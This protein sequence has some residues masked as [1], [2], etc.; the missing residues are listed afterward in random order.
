MNSTV[1][2]PA[3]LNRQYDVFLD[4]CPARH[5]HDRISSKWVSLV[6][7]ALSGGEKRFRDLTR[8]ISG[9][10]QKMLTQT[11]RNLERDG[12]ISR[13]VIATRP[14]QVSYALTPLGQ[15]LLPIFQAIKNWAE[16]HIEEIHDSRER[17]EKQNG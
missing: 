14:V 9:V 5:L 8:S 17:Y 16:A 4:V 11:L 15:S 1:S 10:S 2:E 7:N 6:V 3:E 13:S 12:L